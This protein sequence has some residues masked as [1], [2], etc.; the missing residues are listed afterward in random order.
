[1]RGVAELLRAALDGLTRDR[2]LDASLA[3]PPASRPLDELPTPTKDVLSARA[4]VSSQPRRPRERP[5][6]IA[7]IRENPAGSVGDI[8]RPAALGTMLE[9]AMA[10]ALDDAIDDKCRVIEIRL[11]RDGAAT[12]T[13]IGP[14]FAPER[15]ARGLQRWPWLRRSPAGEVILTQSLAAPV[16]T[17]ALSHWC[18]LEISRAD[19]I[20]RQAF[21]RG[22]PE[23]AM[24]CDPIGP[25]RNTYTRVSFRPDPEIFAE[26]SF[27]ID[28]LYMRGLGFLMELS[29]IELRIHDERTKVPPL[30]MVGTG[31]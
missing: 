16:V 17:C 30:I 3:Q 20:W 9:G 12:V 2:E 7:N 22:E 23:S 8:T 26:L 29:M 10:F 27:S 11:L 5:R 31:I 28:D 6:I 15:A 1:M 19:G 25:G 4:W 21:Y 18:R 13:H 24:R 14:G